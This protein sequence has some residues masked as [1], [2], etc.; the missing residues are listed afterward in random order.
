MVPSLSDVK[1]MVGTVGFPTTVVLL[2]MGAFSWG[3]IPSKLTEIRD[4]VLT[5]KIKQEH[6]AQ[7]MERM[8]D[9]SAKQHAEQLHSLTAAMKQVCINTA[10]TERRLD[11]C[12]KI[13]NRLTP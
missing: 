1:E 9:Q 2:A 4:D 10:R 6:Q 7:L 3:F 12:L 13:D 5:T 8:I 11:D